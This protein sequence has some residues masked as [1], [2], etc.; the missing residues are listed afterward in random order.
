MLIFSFFLQ[1]SKQ[2]S[3]RSSILY[4]F[5]D[6][7]SLLQS[8][9]RRHGG[10]RLSIRS[11]ST[12]TSRTLRDVVIRASRHQLSTSAS[13]LHHRHHDNGFGRTHRLYGAS[14][15]SPNHTAFAANTACPN[16][17]CHTIAAPAVAFKGP[18]WY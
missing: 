6:I 17:R 18:C 10:R 5:A 8:V 9:W 11:W 1:R 2:P 3:T 13:P 4:S 7:E 15:L 16:R 12:Q 14:I